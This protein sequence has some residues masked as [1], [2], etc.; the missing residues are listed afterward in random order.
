MF[1]FEISDV[2][3]ILQG[4]LYLLRAALAPMNAILHHLIMYPLCSGSKAMTSGEY[5]LNVKDGARGRHP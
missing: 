1:N 2:C 5:G 3:F 4:L